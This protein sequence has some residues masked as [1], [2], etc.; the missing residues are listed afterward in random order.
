MPVVPALLEAE[1]VVSLEPRS[2]GLVWTREWELSL[3]VKKTKTF[4]DVI[5]SKNLSDHLNHSL[6]ELFLC[7]ICHVHITI[8]CFN[9]IFSD[10]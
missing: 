3:S 4:I 2:L 5:T 10:R 1:S 8:I 9:S 7:S 6:L